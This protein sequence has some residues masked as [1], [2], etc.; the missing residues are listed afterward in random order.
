MYDGKC[1]VMEKYDLDK[2]RALPIEGV[3]DRLG[4]KVK[5]HKAL[6][7]FHADSHPSL[8]FHVKWNTYKC[9]VCDVHGD[10]ITLVMESIVI[11]G[12]TL[13]KSEDVKLLASLR[14]EK[15]TVFH[16][17]PDKDEAGERLYRQLLQAANEIGACLIRD[18]LPEGYKDFGQWWAHNT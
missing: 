10:P 11:P 9:F 16:I 2:L 17:Y 12:V 3:A 6:C 13:L 18:E 7:P 1:E 8:P 4:L 5:N 14:E 15:K